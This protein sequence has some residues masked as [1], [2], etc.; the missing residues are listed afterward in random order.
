[1]AIIDSILTFLRDRRELSKDR[2]IRISAYIHKIADCCS[3]FIKSCDRLRTEID[4]KTFDAESRN[5]EH[6]VDL[7]DN[8]L[9]MLDSVLGGRVKS[10]T[11]D[12]LAITLSRIVAVEIPIVKFRRRYDV[13]HHYSIEWRFEDAWRDYPPY[14]VIFWAPAQRE[15]G[16]PPVQVR[17]IWAVDNF[18]EKMLSEI[19]KIKDIKPEDSRYVFPTETDILECNIKVPKDSDL[20]SVNAFM[21]E[22]SKLNAKLVSLAD[23]I[24]A[25]ARL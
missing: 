9:R 1:M 14:A 11:L 5:L 4:E 23:A 2:R 20:P 15:G 18:S 17:V 21:T 19:R 6:Q 3:S 24:E 13:K 22:L 10:E 25:G 7:V 16:F 8:Y 12:N